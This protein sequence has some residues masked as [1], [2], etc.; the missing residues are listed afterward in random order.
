MA[1]AGIIVVGSRI[2][3]RDRGHKSAK[4]QAT[5]ASTRVVVG[6]IMVQ[7]IQKMATFPI[8]V[9]AKTVSSSDTTIS[10]G[11][12]NIPHEDEPFDLP[13]P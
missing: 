8:G 2:L 9:P 10:V 1:K 13:R 4:Q 6:R 7:S 12:H 3:A 5:F 11:R